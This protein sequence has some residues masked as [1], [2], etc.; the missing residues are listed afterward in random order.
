MTSWFHEKIA[1][2]FLFVFCI[3]NLC[4]IWFYF[5]HR[6]LFFQL[7]GQYCLDLYITFF[8]VPICLTL[9]LDGK[10]LE[11][12]TNFLL[13]FT[14]S[15]HHMTFTQELNIKLM[16]GLVQRSKTLIF[17]IHL[18]LYFWKRTPFGTFNSKAC[19]NI[20]FKII[21]FREEDKIK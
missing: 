8:V 3:F 13:H 1:Y 17:Y 20:C 10:F 16:P 9:R 4:N 12:R 15:T 6:Q 2:Y 21:I 14:P 19:H 7:Y 11:D 18:Y 5:I